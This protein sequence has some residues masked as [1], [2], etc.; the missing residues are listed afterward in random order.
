M[1]KG[2][3]SSAR[4]LPMRLSFM[5]V[6]AFRLR[7]NGPVGFIDTRGRVVI[8]AKFGTRFRSPPVFAEGLAAVG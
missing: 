1:P 4:A 8:A 2:A 5:G 3:G 6:G 7:E